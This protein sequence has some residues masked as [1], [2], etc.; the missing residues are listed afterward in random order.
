MLPSGVSRQ[1]N[2]ATA[3]ENLESRINSAPSSWSSHRTHSSLALLL[4]TLLISSPPRAHAQTIMSLLRHAVAGA[5]RSSALLRTTAAPLR[6][7]STS[8]VAHSK[9]PQLGDY[10]DLPY[11]SQQ[12]RKYSPKWWDPQEKRN[13]G[14]TVSFPTLAP[15]PIRSCSLSC[16]LTPWFRFGSFAILTAP[17]ARRRALG[18]G[19]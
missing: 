15:Q 1:P 12:Q 16:V 11:V 9:D 14:E 4:H 19:S 3:S 5:S 18:M 13:F 7:L 8:A 10:P 6:T 17:R 2:I